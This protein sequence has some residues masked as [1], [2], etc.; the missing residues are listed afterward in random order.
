MLV[1]LRQRQ[2]EIVQ[3]LQYFRQLIRQM[4]WLL[5]RT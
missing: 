2:R 5:F 3:M 1:H 4:K